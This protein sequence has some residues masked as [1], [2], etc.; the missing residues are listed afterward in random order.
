MRKST[1][2]LL[3]TACSVAACLLAV[4]HAA[5]RR[6]YDGRTER[7][8]RAT[9]VRELRLTDLCLFTDARYTR[10]PAMADRHAPFQEHPVALEHFPSGS[11]LSPPAGLERPHE[12]LR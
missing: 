5:F 7:R 1:I 8:H 12:H 10:N 11:F 9:L 2:Y 4:L 3:F 6:H